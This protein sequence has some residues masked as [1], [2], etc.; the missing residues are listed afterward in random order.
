M[1]S[2]YSC[3]FAVVHTL[4]RLCLL[5]KVALFKF[6]R[7]LAG[8]IYRLPL[9]TKQTNIDKLRNAFARFQMSVTLT[10]NVN[11]ATYLIT[12]TQQAFSRFQMPVTLPDNSTH[13]KTTR[14][15]K[16][17][18]FRDKVRQWQWRHLPLNNFLGGPNWCRWTVQNFRMR[19]H[20][21]GVLCR[22]QL[23]QFET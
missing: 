18:P 16:W 10:S 7:N 6:E 2:T 14:E 1:F 22:T 19:P 8:Q 15:A 4:L 23:L 3:V 20:Y 21:E 11:N 9:K 17:T 12:A 5:R 13:S